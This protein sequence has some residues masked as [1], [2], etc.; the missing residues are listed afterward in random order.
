MEILGS[1]ELDQLSQRCDRC[2]ALE[3]VFLH[4]ECHPEAPMWCK[5]YGGILALECSACGK[6]VVCIFVR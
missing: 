5:Y 4:S 3:G 2:D 6:I 1:H